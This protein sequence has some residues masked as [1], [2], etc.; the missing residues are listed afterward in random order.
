[1]HECTP[2]LDAVRTIT[3][4]CIKSW[5]LLDVLLE[6]H[7]QDYD[8][9]FIQE[10]P[11]QV[12]RT[13]PSVRSVEGEDVTGAPNHPDWL[14]MVRPPDPDTSPRV[15]AYVSTRL[16]VWRLSMC[17]DIIDHRD[18]LML[19]LFADKH[20]FNFMNVYSDSEFS[21]IRYLSDHADMLP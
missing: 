9:M 5:L 20:T 12:I 10:P 6:Y 17:C 18:I 13:A 11:W 21:A 1:M 15:L 4:N 16:H 7:K 19:S 14:A 2:A 8:I 3:Y